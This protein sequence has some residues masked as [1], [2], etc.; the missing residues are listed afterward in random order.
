MMLGSAFFASV[1]ERTYGGYASTTP[2]LG[3]EFK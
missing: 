3:T 2:E 1:F